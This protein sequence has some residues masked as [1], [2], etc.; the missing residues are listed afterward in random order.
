MASPRSVRLESHALT[1]SSFAMT[2]CRAS[3]F[4]TLSK[5]ISTGCIRAETHADQLSSVDLACRFCPDSQE[6][7]NSAR[8]E[9]ALKE[10]QKLPGNK[11]CADCSGT[12]AL[13]RYAR[14]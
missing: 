2:Y 12:G 11:K 14:R 13:V 7:N 9:K 6:M 8:L 3:K 4:H 10:I 5:A 1:G